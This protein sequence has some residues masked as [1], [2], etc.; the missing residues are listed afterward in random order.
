MKNPLIYIVLNRELKMS[1]GK[2]AA[3]TAHA[4]AQLHAIYGLHKFS[5]EVK[6]TVVVLEAKNQLQMDN[7][8]TYLM[9]LSIPCA[10]YIDE[11]VNEVD[12][13]S[14][15][16]LAAGPFEAEDTESR[17]MFSSF[18]LYQGCI[19]VKKVDRFG[20]PEEEAKLEN[21]AEIEGFWSFNAIKR[22]SK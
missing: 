1:P 22:A 18:D 21:N 5:E 2:A 6:R 7:L 10:S 17:S 19:T 15:T 14:V 9:S 12:A 3:Q 13:Y 20:L 11:G 4:M 16:A 8:E